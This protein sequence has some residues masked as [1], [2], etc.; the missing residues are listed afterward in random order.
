MGSA[1]LMV[2]QLRVRKCPQPSGGGLAGAS[3]ASSLSESDAETDDSGGSTNRPARRRPRPASR[4]AA[5]VRRGKWTPEEEAYAAR[6]IRDFDAGLLPL[7]NGATLRV[8]L[9]EKLNCDPMRISKKF[10]GINC[11]GKV[12][13]VYPRVL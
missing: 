8:Y 5:G 6:L 4:Q 2:L 10:T 9:A 12:A 7:E 1:A 11:I 13:H 3:Y